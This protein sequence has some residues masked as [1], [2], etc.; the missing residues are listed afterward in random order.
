MTQ[1]SNPNGI[2][3]DYV[4]KLARLK[5][6]AEEQ[7]KFSTQ[8]GS[9]LDYCRKISA[10]DVE[11]VEPTAHAFPLYN[12]WAADAAE[13][14]LTTEQALSNAPSQ[15]DNQVVVPKGIEES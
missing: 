6:T 15:R 7:K 4:A 2:D 5:L 14:G 11:G 8:L 3:V 12:V 1:S 9:I 13:A 10:V